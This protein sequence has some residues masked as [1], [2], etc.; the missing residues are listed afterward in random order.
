MAFVLAF[1]SSKEDAYVFENE[2]VKG[3]YKSEVSLNLQKNQTIIIAEIH[4]EMC[5]E[6]K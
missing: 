6:Y 4:K 1:F 2:R 5:A 3:S